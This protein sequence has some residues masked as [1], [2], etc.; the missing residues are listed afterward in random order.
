MQV[1]EAIQDYQYYLTMVERKAKQTIASYLRDLHHYAQYL[2]ELGIT[3]VEEIRESDVQD[4]LLELGENAANATINRHLSSIRSFHRF[5]SMNHPQLPDPSRFLKGSKKQAHLPHFL[6]ESQIHT[7]LESFS[8]SDL[9]LCHK[10]VI[11]LLYGCGLRVSECCELR[12]S[13][14]HLEQGLLKVNGK[15]SK[16]RMLPLHQE[17]VTCLRQYLRFVRPQWEQVRTPYVF[18]NSRGHPL[19]RQYVHQMIKAQLK[20]L[21]M[22]SDYSAHSFRHSFAT[23]LLDGGADLRIVQEL[24]GHSDIQTTQ[25][26]THVQ[27]RRLQQAY[28]SYHPFAK[29]ENT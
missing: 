28:Q 14:L 15:G 3:Q 6:N 19:T 21:G 29:K 9:D 1:A 25:I 7:I 23:H 4:F 22:R 5:L 8:D 13:N 2:Q 18:I 12:L 26:Y 16:E 10:A 24:L 17:G 11:E 20:A 27:N